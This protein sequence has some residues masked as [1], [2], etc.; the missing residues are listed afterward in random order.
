MRFTIRDVL[1]IAV[2]AALAVSWWVDNRR[3]DN[4]VARV[5]SERREL[6]KERVAQKAELIKMTKDRDTW[7]NLYKLELLRSVDLHKKLVA[8]KPP[9]YP[10]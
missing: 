5:E 6:E 9:E 4:A 8:K 2:V 1:W 7:L 10:N 3:I